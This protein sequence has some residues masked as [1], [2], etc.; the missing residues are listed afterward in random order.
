[1]LAEW[2]LGGWV[3]MMGRAPRPDDLIVPLPPDA[4]EQRTGEPFR[5][6][7]DSSER[8][9]KEDLPALEWRHGRHYEMRA[10][11]ITLAMDDGADPRR[12]RNPCDA[13]ADVAQRVRRL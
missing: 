7:D 10:T 8:W 3:E 6:H 2:K 4:A 1:M 12:A 5:R 13:Y 9:R 11:F